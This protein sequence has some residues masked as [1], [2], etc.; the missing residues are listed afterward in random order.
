MEQGNINRIYCAH[1]VLFLA[2]A[3]CILQNSRFRDM[4]MNFDKSVQESM[5]E[6][7]NTSRTYKVHFLSL[8]YI[9]A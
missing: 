6:S 3:L 1:T 2:T 8:F 9:H 5:C 4:F 7:I